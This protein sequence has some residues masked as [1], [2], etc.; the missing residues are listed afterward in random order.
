MTLSIPDSFGLTTARM[1]RP[2][3][4][5]EVAPVKPLVSTNKAQAI[6]LG[7]IGLPL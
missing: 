7:S 3:A 4:F 1:F 2:Q 6:V 5:F